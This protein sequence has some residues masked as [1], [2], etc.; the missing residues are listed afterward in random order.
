MEVNLH[1]VLWRSRANGPG[2]RAVLWFQG[3]TLGCPGC[4]NPDTHPHE[5]RLVVPVS[6][7]VAGLKAQAG[8]IEG[9]T[10]SGGEPLEQKAALLELLRGVR[11]ATGLSVIL[12]TGWTWEELAGLPER[13][14]LLSYVDVTLCGR[15]D[16]GRQPA[17][18]GLLGSP[19][20][21][22]HRVTERYTLAD[23]AVVPDAEV[24]VSPEGEVVVSGIAP[25]TH[26]SASRR[27][28]QVTRGWG[29]V[30]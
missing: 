9:L 5:L 11:E 27:P 2:L 6:E 24:V 15:H 7:L 10:L 26:Y 25:P 30:P 13:E 1:A 22:V 17:G 18:R 16:A 23:L 8:E 12:F 19:G 21:T 4:F 14:E 28:E 3:C 29:P 20:K